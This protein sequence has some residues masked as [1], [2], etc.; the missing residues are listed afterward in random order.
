MQKLFYPP[1]ARYN[2]MVFCISATCFELRVIILSRSSPTSLTFIL[3]A[4]I[5]LSNVPEYSSDLNHSL[6]DTSE[7]TLLETSSCIE[8]SKDSS[9]SVRS[10]ALLILSQSLPK[11]PTFRKISLAEPLS[12]RNDKYAVLFLWFLGALL[13]IYKEA[14]LPSALRSSVNS[15][16]NSLLTVESAAK[17]IARF[18]ALFIESSLCCS[19]FAFSASTCAIESVRSRA[20]AASL[21]C[22]CLA[23]SP[24]E[25]N[26]QI[27]AKAM[28]T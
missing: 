21:S 2:L 22:L 1:K 16:S 10:K 11:Y 23:D 7:L 19:I 3:L 15:G 17:R 13:I 24:H 12:T 27:K 5:S 18:S 6:H 20:S 25:A 14:P 9:L 28:I 4:S 8:R 26:K